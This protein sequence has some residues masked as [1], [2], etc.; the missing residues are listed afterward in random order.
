MPHY[1]IRFISSL[2]K[3]RLRISQELPAIRDSTRKVRTVPNRIDELPAIATD[4]EG[5]HGRLPGI[6]DKITTVHDEL[7]A[8]S[9]KVAAIHGELLPRMQ[10]DMQRLLVPFPCN[11]Q[12]TGPLT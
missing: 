3:C 6:A 10:D 12:S 7:P 2:S 11:D 4:L 1:C 8:I 9:G 5:S